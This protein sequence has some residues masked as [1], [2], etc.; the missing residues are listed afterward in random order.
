MRW[1]GKK[2]EKIHSASEQ[3]TEDP[4]IL[5]LEAQFDQHVTDIAKI[6]NWCLGFLE[7][8]GLS[9]AGAHLGAAIN[10]LPGKAAVPP[11]ELLDLIADLPAVPLPPRVI[12]GRCALPKIFMEAIRPKGSWLQGMPGGERKGLLAAA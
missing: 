10:A 2:A 12:N 11:I 5:R 3:A 8:L 4:E 1:Q 9:Q 6:L 7:E